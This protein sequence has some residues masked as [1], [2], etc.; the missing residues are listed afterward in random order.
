MTNLN[1]GFLMLINIPEREKERG[2]RRIRRE[3]KREGGWKFKLVL[4]KI[5]ELSENVLNW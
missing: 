4:R 1:T 3:G 2:E 5:L